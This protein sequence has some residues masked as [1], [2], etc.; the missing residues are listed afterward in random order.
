[1]SERG[2]ARVA[3]GNSSASKL[4]ILHLDTGGSLRQRDIYNDGR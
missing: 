3:A 1:M 2:A 4:P